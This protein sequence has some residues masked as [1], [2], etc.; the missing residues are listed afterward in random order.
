[1]KKKIILLNAFLILCFIGLVCFPS[2]K[3]DLSNEFEMQGLVWNTVAYYYNPYIYWITY[4]PVNRKIITKKAGDFGSNYFLMKA[5][6]N[7]SPDGGLKGNDEKQEKLLRKAINEVHKKGFKV[8]LVPFVD[9]QDYCVFKRWILNEDVWT[10]KVLQ[11]ADFAEQNNVEMFA[12][13]IEMNLIFPEER[14]GNWFKEIL[15]KIKNVYSGSIATSEHPY[16]GKWEAIDNAG[17]FEGYDCIGVSLYPWE[18]Y[19]GKNDIKSLEEYGDHIYEKAKLALNTAE[20]YGIDCKI[21]APLGMD[22]WKGGFPDAQA[23][24]EGFDAALDILSDLDFDGVFLHMWM[25]ESDHKG[26]TTS[27]GNMLKN[28]W[29]K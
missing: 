20:K 14:I 7:G 17:G 27:V 16:L 13:G 26:I 8:F 22:F 12:P 6:Y 4:G 11:W 5:F 3:P 10:E 1:V 21:V 15:P 18:D 2:K 23:R 25:S 19:N 24:A 28:R 29:L 9:S